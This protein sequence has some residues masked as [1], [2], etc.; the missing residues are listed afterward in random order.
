MVLL[1]KDN[2][3]YISSST[4]KLTKTKSERAIINLQGGKK[5]TTTTKPNLEQKEKRATK[6]WKLWSQRTSS[7]RLSGSKTVK[8][9]VLK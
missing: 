5:T 1:V 7:N 6:F 3:L 2:R 9:T 8:P 4:K